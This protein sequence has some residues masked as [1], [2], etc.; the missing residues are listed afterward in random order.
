MATC[1]R[2]APLYGREGRSDEVDKPSPTFF[3]VLEATRGSSPA[4][5]ASGAIAPCADVGSSL[6]GRAIAQGLHASEQQGSTGR[7]ERKGGLHRAIG[8]VALGHLS[9]SSQ[10]RSTRGNLA[11]HCAGCIRALSAARSKGLEGPACLRLQHAGCSEHQRQAPTPDPFA[12]TCHEREMRSWH[13][14]S[15]RPLMARQTLAARP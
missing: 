12:T 7:E 10:R 6:E 13:A 2:A 14:M 11:Q 4:L 5:C 8:V 9:H 15:R 1:P 3:R